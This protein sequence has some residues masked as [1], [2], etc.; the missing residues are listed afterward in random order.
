MLGTIHNNIKVMYAFSLFCLELAHHNFYYTN[1]IVVVGI[2]LCHS[3]NVD[4]RLYDNEGV[5]P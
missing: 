3:R 5:L 1:M 2:H 4:C